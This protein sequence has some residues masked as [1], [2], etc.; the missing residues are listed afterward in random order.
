VRDGGRAWCVNGGLGSGRRL[1]VTEEPSDCS[2]CMSADSTVDVW[3]ARTELCGNVEEDDLLPA[4]RAR[5]V[6]LTM[7]QLNSFTHLDNAHHTLDSALLIFLLAARRGSGG[8]CSWL[9]RHSQEGEVKGRQRTER[10]SSLALLERYLIGSDIVCV[11]MIWM[12]S[13]NHVYVI[14][15]DTSYLRTVLL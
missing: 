4:R 6:S 14:E 10:I 8:R 2:R 11:N 13:I 15:Y 7:F 12:H 5:S 3:V 1:V 9:I